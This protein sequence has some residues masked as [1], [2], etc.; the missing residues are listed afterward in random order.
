[1]SQVL[2]LGLPTVV[3]LNMIDVA[4]RQGTS[5]STS[6]KLSERLGVSGSF[7]VQANRGSGIAELKQALAAAAAAHAAK[8]AL[9]ARFRRVSAQEVADAGGAKSHANGRRDRAALSRR[10]AAARYERLF[11]KAGLPGIDESLLA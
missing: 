2:E 6:H 10:A 5:R 9:R 1:M 4:Q 7:E 8:S 11:G 3:A